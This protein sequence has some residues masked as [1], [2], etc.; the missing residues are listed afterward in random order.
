MNREKHDAI[1]LGRLGEACIALTLLADTMR[2]LKKA[3]AE[4]V[5][6]G[7]EGERRPACQACGESPK[8][9]RLCEAVHFFLDDE[10]EPDDTAYKAWKCWD[11]AGY[12]HIDSDYKLAKKFLRR[13]FKPARFKGRTYH[14][15]P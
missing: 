6:L 14:L 13:K 2:R 15:G 11:V 10:F 12:G 1:F 3:H 7:C 8:G 5:Q 9:C 4:H